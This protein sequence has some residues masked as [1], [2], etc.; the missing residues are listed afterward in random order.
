VQVQ[1]Q[2]CQH[3]VMQFTEKKNRQVRAHIHA[4]TNDGWLNRNTRVATQY[5]RANGDTSILVDIGEVADY[6]VKYVSKPE[7]SS[8]SG[9]TIGVM[10]EILNST[11][12]DHPV[13]KIIRRL[14]MKMKPERDIGKEEIT[15]RLLQLPYVSQDI[16]FVRICLDGSRG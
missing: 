8:K 2:L 9:E 10:H 15:H 7:K 16:T 1:V 11:E 6:M 14:F 4:A 3:T 13:S 5:F 12:E